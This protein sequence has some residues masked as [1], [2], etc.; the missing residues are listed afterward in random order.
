MSLRDPDNSK[1]VAYTT[2]GTFNNVP[3][4]TLQDGG[5]TAIIKTLNL[6]G[7]ELGSATITYEPRT[8][9]A[10]FNAYPSAT[11][12]LG[13][14]RITATGLGAVV[15]NGLTFRLGV[16]QT[17]PTRS[18]MSFK[19]TLGGLINPVNG[20]CTLQLL[21][22]RDNLR[23]DGTL[24]AITNLVG[25]ILRLLP[26]PPVG[27][28]T[29][30]PVESKVVAP[31]PKRIIVQATGYGPRGA[32]KKL[33]MMV[34]RANFDFE[35]PATV[36]LRGATNCAPMTFATGNSNAKEYKGADAS[37]A[38]AARPAFAINGCDYD[39]GV[40]GTGNPDTVSGSSQ[41]GILDNGTA[42]DAPMTSTPVDTPAFLENAD[43]ARQYVNDLEQTARSQ[44]R[45]FKS[46]GSMSVNSGTSS[47][48]AFTF[49]DGDCDLNGGA[50]LL[51][52]TGNLEMSGNPSFDGVILVLGKGNVNRNGG[53]NGT[54][55]GTMIVAR[56]D[57]TWP[58][59]ENALPHPFRAPTFNTN[60]GGN[61]TM[62]YS[63][64]AVRRALGMVG[65]PRV[66]GVAEL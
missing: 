34:S 30:V 45:Y 53:G 38:E 42:P 65:G 56:F 23:V 1:S 27:A 13:R 66:S 43:K 18:R 4:V 39:D 46:A 22:S 54:V 7:L 28:A 14:F 37:G 50:G 51:V 5:R 6:L 17:V 60:G 63:S 3:G 11:T 47:A 29:V 33:E 58:T 59:I 2:T 8:N 24:I 31:E 10:A 57:R 64:E 16:E 48:P 26:L 19:A 44:G 32:R 62:Q 52:V 61:S 36:T 35:S 40:W 20:L 41:F 49:V 9:N 25:K 15:P 55:S 21:F 12:D